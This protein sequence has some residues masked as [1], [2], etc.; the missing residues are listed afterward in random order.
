MVLVC[1]SG[2]CRV[3]PLF[4]IVSRCSGKRKD[5]VSKKWTIFTPVTRVT[6]GFGGWRPFLT[7]IPTGSWRPVESPSFISHS[8]EKM[9]DP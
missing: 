5:P 7:K 6:E 8:T 3:S 2:T 9:G 4:L 1:H